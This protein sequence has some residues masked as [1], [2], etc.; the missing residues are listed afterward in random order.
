M[1]SHIQKLKVTEMRMLR[2]MYGLTRGDRV[3]NEIIREKVGVASVEDKMREVRLRW[4]GHMMRRGTNALVRRCERLA[5]DGFRRGRG[6]PKKYWREV[7]RRDMEQFQLIEDMTLDRKIWRTRIRV[8]CTDFIT[9]PYLE[10]G[11]YRK[12]PCY[13]SGGSVEQANAL[14]F[15][16]DFLGI[17]L[18]EQPNKYYFVIR[19][20]RLIVEA[21]SSIQAIMEKLQSYKTRVALNFEGFQYQLGDFQLRVGK[22]VPIHSENLRGIVM[23]MEYL[24]ISSWEKSHQIMGEFFDIWQE[25]LGKRSL[26]GH[27]VHIEPNF[28]EFGLSDQYIS[29]HTAVQYAS[30]MAQMI[31]T[32]HS[33][34]TGRN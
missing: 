34:Q 3:R 26:P 11:V 27:F 25:A 30:I 12:Q 5:L 18:Q 1:N 24:P 16:R 15:P 8:F 23:E 4:F 9:I 2:W 17:S 32:A 28:S 6:R 10:P 21:E 22:V 13:F 14:D 29:Q 19:G 31:A 7:I 20:Q 33:A